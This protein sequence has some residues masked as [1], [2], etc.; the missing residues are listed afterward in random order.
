MKLIFRAFLSF[1]LVFQGTLAF[2]GP[3]KK[4]GAEEIKN[5][6]AQVTANLAKRLNATRNI[7]ETINFALIEES[8]KDRQ[9][10]QEQILNSRVKKFPK[11]LVDRNVLS[12]EVNKQKVSIEV[13]NPLEN[14]FKLNGYEFKYDAQKTAK[15]RMSYLERVFKYKKQALLFNLLIEEAKADGGLIALLV[16]IFGGY[17]VTLALEESGKK[18]VEENKKALAAFREKYP[19]S[20][21]ELRCASELGRPSTLIFGETTHDIKSKSFASTF[22]E[23]KNLARALQSCCGTKRGALYRQTC[24]NRI[25]EA[26]SRGESQ[27]TTTTE[28]SPASEGRP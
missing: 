25:N 17:G 13:L 7:Y 22:A 5:L 2:A 24:S 21:I 15:E 4:A 26:L 18:E 8:K 16:V 14:K 3:T 11:V 20:K 19:K 6:S 9:Y 27:A 1:T 23:Q 28:S 10:L 12:F